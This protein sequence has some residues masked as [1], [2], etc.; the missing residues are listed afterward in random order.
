MGSHGLMVWKMW[1]LSWVLVAGRRVKLFLSGVDSL[2]PGWPLHKSRDF[3]PISDAAHP[4]AMSLNLLGE[5][6]C[7]PLLVL[8]KTFHL[9]FQ[10]AFIFKL[11]PSSLDRRYQDKK[12]QQL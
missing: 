3:I 8:G 4:Q 2:N 1:E 9:V 5:E 7:K 12:N 11:S 10:Q 6:S